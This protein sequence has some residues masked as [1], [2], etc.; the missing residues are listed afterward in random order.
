MVRIVETTEPKPFPPYT[1]FGEY[2]PKHGVSAENSVKD[3]GYAKFV[4][5]ENNCMFVG[6]IYDA[7]IRHLLARR[8]ELLK[9]VEA[10]ASTEP[11]TEQTTLDQMTPEP[12]AEEAEAPEETEE[13]PDT[14]PAEQK[15]EEEPQQR[16]ADMPL[17]EVERR[18]LGF[19]ISVVDT[20]AYGVPEDRFDVQ[21]R[22]VDL[23]R[24]LTKVKV[25]RLSCCPGADVYITKENELRCSGC[26]THI[27]LDFVKAPARAK[28]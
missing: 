18:L 24:E 23:V 17:E 3:G 27:F 21:H 2:T 12:K 4:R 22:Y 13:T 15:P 26:G 7:E 5:V 19:N 25:L 20:D 1:Y 28:V 9:P 6:E 14:P 10:E 8:Q 11:A 16:Y